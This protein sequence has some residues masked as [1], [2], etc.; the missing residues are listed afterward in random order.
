MRGGEER[1]K[2]GGDGR[3]KEEKGGGRGSGK[4]GRRLRRGPLRILAGG[5]QNVK[6]RHCSSPPPTSTSCHQKH[7]GQNAVK[8]SK[9]TMRIDVTTT[10]KVTNKFVLHRIQRTERRKQ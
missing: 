5:A 3:G 2:R 10:G 9:R 6:L 7:L 4:G 1:E 8:M